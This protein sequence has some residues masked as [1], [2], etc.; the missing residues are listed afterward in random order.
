MA[1]TGKGEFAVSGLRIGGA[2]GLA[3]ATTPLRD[4]TS[5]NV[6]MEAC[7]WLDRYILV[8]SCEVSSTSPSTNNCLCSSRVMMSP[9]RKIVRLRR[10]A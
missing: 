5:I 3:L 8:G 1:S 2:W 9:Q 6:V 4:A 10:L 7:F